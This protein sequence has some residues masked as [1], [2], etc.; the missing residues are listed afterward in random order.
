[1]LIFIL[2]LSTFINVTKRI[3][4][5]L[6]FFLIFHSSKVGFS[7]YIIRNIIKFIFQ[8]TIQNN[9]SYSIFNTFFSQTE[10]IFATKSIPTIET[11]NIII[12]HA[13]WTILM[14][15]VVSLFDGIKLIMQQTRYK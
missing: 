13:S 11:E 15:S 12:S 14:S 6:L 3:F 1:M 8:S 10:I 9:I 4:L 7:Y 2:L 5:K